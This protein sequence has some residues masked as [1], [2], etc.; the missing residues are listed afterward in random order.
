MNKCK[1]CG[2][3]LQYDNE[4]SLGYSPKEGSDYCQRCFRLTHYD[5]LNISM[6]KGIDSVDVLRRINEYDALILW[7]VDLFDFEASMIS[8][9]NR[10]LPN[11][12]II[13]VITKRDLLP[14]TLSNEK[15]ERFILDRL[16]DYNINL[17]GIVVTGKN[18]Q[19]GNEEIF[20]IIEKFYNDRDIIVMGKANAG[21]STMLNELISNNTLTSS[22]YPG[23][24][25]DFNPLM[26]NGFRFIDTPGIEGENT[27]LMNV[28]ENDLKSILPFEK[29]KPRGYQVNRNQS[30]SLGGLVRFD[31][32]SCEKASVVFYIS[33]RC[34]IHRGKFEN[35]DEFWNKHLNT[36]LKPV[37]INQNYTKLKTVSGLQKID[38]VVDGLGWVSIT[39]KIKEIIVNYPKNIN[40]IIRKAMI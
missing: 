9:I 40:I 14:I 29:I 8:G 37:S 21:K 31:F 39:G 7:V 20:K 10:H 2:I 4:S 25:L 1:G 30:F 34:M 12:D 28:C 26:I 36:L 5:D 16:S 11:K 15:L 22:R 17:L 23:T 13:L 33:N 24:T 35:A 18:I 38:I 6:S 32:L 27:M 3:E 19:S